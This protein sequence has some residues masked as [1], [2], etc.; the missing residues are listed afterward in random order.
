MK[1][2]YSN[3]KPTKPR[4]TLNKQIASAPTRAAKWEIALTG[5]LPATKIQMLATQAIHW[6]FSTEKLEDWQIKA[7]ERL[8]QDFAN[9][10]FPALVN[11]DPAAFFELLE[12][13]AK[14]RREIT[15]AKD[16]LVIYGNRPKPPPKR[17][18]GRKLRLAILDLQPDDL[19]SIKAVLEFLES[20]QVEFSDESHVRRVMREMKIRL[21]TPGDTVYLAFSP[22]DPATGGP[23]KFV[24]VRKFVVNGDRTITNHGMSRKDYDALLGCKAHHVVPAGPVKADK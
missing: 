11:N 14:L 13:M 16:G 6:K 15:F 19:T 12:A 17:E 2:A 3:V 10:L 23:K 22:I 21:L 7:K 4:N 24:S 1:K 5:G 20:R 18:A 9:L 8:K